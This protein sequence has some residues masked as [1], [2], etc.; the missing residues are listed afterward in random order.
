MPN[1]VREEL[2]GRGPVGKTAGVWTKDRASNQVAA[3]VVT[4]TDKETLQG[5]V[6]DNAY[7]EVTVYT[8]DATAYESLPF[9]HDTVKH[10]LQEYVKG[11]VHTNGIESLGSMLKRAPKGPLKEITRKSRTSR[12][13]GVIGVIQE[14]D[15]GC[16]WLVTTTRKDDGCTVRS[17]D[18][19]KLYPII[20]GNRYNRKKKTYA[21]P[22]CRTYRQ[23]DGSYISLVDESDFIADADK[24][25][26]NA[27][28][29]SENANEFE[30]TKQR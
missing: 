4:S 17:I 19:A 1:H 7:P 6:K 2:T 18:S 12:T 8:D 28:A 26:E 9:D 3:K 13:N 15:G 20:R 27:F 25:I 14:V 5:F 23:L 22:N 30:L 10:S 21:C 29:K 16:D 11:D 24:Y